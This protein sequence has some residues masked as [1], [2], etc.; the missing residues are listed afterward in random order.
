MKCPLCKEKTTVI[1][2]RAGN[3]KRYRCR[4]CK[5]CGYVFYT[6]EV[7]CTGRALLDVTAELM[8]INYQRK[9]TTK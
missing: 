1:E 2:S 5:K 8:R 3:G 4:R 7:R 6:E 9:K